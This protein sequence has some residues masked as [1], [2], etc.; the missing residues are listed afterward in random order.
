M[1]VMTMGKAGIQRTGMSLHNGRP[2][3]KEKMPG[4]VVFEQ[5]AQ[6]S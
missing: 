1:S 3:E 6:F 5:Q 2:T 4:G